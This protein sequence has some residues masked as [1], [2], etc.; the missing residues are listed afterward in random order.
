MRITNIK[1]ENIIVFLFFL[2]I[3]LIGITV[4]KDYGLTIDDQ[5]YWDTGE[6][7]YEYVKILFSSDNTGIVNTNIEKLS[8]EIAG[9]QVPYVAP[10]LFELPLV[11][12]T[13]FLNINNSKEIYELCHLVNFLIFFVSLISFFK[14]IHTNQ[15][16]VIY[17]MIAV[18][19]LFSTPRFFAESF[20]NSRDIFFL[21]LFI[22]YLHALQNFIYQQNFSCN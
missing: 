1:T 3:F 5:I 11:A 21:S 6:F 9:Y 8:Q 7:Y 20:Y 12:L 10:V 22:F 14:F 18:T 17:S 16:S 15:K 19:I 2:I 13:K 4:Y